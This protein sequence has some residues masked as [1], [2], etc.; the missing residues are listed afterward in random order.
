MSLP[1][2]HKVL[3][4]ENDKGDV[5]FVENKS[6]KSPLIE[7]KKSEKKFEAIEEDEEEKYITPVVIK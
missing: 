2:Y 1:V 3:I 7:E 6:S 5:F 4:V